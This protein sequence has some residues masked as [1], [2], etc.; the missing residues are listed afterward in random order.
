MDMDS[1]EFRY[2][3]LFFRKQGVFQKGEK[4]QKSR[5]DFRKVRWASEKQEGFRK[6][7]KTAEKWGF[8]RKVAGFHHELPSLDIFTGTAR[9][10]SEKISTRQKFRTT[11]AKLTY[12][13]QI[14]N[15]TRTA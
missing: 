9:I 13:Q 12:C 2:H 6:V 8:S 7:G 1:D 3:G 10:S 5:E 4:L 11:A 15:S 14:Y